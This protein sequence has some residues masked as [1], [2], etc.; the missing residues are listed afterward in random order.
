MIDKNLL[1]SIPI[2]TM[3]DYL[4]LTTSSTYFNDL[5][6]K[7]QGSNIKLRILPTII[8]YFFL[9]FGLNHFILSKNKSADEAFLLGVVIYGVYE[10]TN[11]AILENW[12]T[13]AVVMDTLWGGI[14]FYLTA[15]FTYNLKERKTVTVLRY[16]MNYVFNLLMYGT[17]QMY[18]SNQTR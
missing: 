11:Y 8:C 13:K 14:L 5:I 17:P 18:T 2:F 9:I 1:I 6:N 12:S 16:M 7:I 10:T 15:Y 3:I 4:Y